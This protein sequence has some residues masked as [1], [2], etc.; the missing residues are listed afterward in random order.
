MRLDITK[1]YH[2]QGLIA[3]SFVSIVR[4]EL[5]WVG[6]EALKGQS[7]L[8]QAKLFVGYLAM[9]REILMTAIRIG[10]L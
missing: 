1:C 9:I 10:H 2:S 6:P 5:Q 7:M 4:L 8:W 3:T